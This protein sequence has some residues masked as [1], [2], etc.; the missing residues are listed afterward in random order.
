MSVNSLE[1]ALRV[2]NVRRGH[3]VGG[4]ETRGRDV[5]TVIL[6]GF[7]ETSTSRRNMSVISGRDKRNRSRRTTVGVASVIDHSLK[8]INRP[9]DLV[10]DDMVVDRTSCSLKSKVRIQEEVVLIRMGD[11]ALNNHARNRIVVGVL[12]SLIHREEAEV[13]ALGTNHNSDL[14]YFGTTRST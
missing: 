5:E 3:D 7:M 1:G 10:K 8:A 2:I 9:L 6:D 4:P 13:V 11:I 14:R 12:A